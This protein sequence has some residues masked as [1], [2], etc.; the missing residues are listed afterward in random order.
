[1]YE[2]PDHRQVVNEV[3]FTEQVAT[4]S[5]VAGRLFLSGSKLFLDTGTD[6]ELIT[7]T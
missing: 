6:M 2:A 5:G 1:M 3:V 7:S 4:I